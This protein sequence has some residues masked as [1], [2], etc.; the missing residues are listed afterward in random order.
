MKIS[1]GLSVVVPAFAQEGTIQQDLRRLSHSLREIADEYQILLVVDGD[2]DRTAELAG[3]V[4]EDSL[5][6][7]VLPENRGK[8][9][10]LR[11]GF[12]SA[13]GRVVGFIDAG[14]DIDP[15]G[16]ATAARLV[17]SET[18]DI[19]I[20]SKRHP[21]SEVG[22]PLL[23][24]IYSWGYQMLCHLLFGLE[25]RDT[26]VG[27]KF[28]SAEVVEVVVPDLVVDGFPCDIELL[29][30]A[31]R[32][33][34]RRVVECPVTLSLEFPSSVNAFTVVRML[35]DTLKVFYRMRIRK[36]YDAPRG[37]RPH[38]QRG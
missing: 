35:F 38:G 5:Q 26:Q 12:S 33:G 36:L 10:A 22:Y 16:I 34:F 8:G 37:G 9:Y 2:V 19:A 32:R 25:A 24:R 15:A 30:L 28:M 27:L 23:R 21:E 14:M 1:G 7:I 20:G 3:A 17:A 11:R 6:V 18:A 31:H 13:A 29:A 4:S